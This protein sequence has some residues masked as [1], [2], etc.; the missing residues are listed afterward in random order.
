M[1]SQRVRQELGTE[2]WNNS[3][4]VISFSFFLFS[5]QKQPK[6]LILSDM[7]QFASSCPLPGF[8]VL[9]EPGWWVQI[10]A[11][12]N[13]PLCTIAVELVST[14]VIGGN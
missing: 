13:F 4:A 7:I 8:M 3:L 2:Q 10:Q 12:T 14:A 1:G 6:I 9:Q 5:E 11:Q